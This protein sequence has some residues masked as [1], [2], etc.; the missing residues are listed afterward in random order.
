MPL[1]EKNT[2]SL[3]NGRHSKYTKLPCHSHHSPLTVVIQSL[4]CVRLWDAMDCSR[5]VCRLFCPLL[6]PRVCS[7]SYPLSGW[8]YLTI[9]SSATPFSF[10]LQSFPASGSFP[11]S[12]LFT[13]G[14]QGFGGSASASVLP[15]N[16]QGW[17]P[18]GLT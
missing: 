8:C 11:M 1:R 18:L 10:C 7:N 14:S 12:E 4:G 2:H 3:Q 5:A 9:S 6:S 13:S 16:I 17:F 15:K